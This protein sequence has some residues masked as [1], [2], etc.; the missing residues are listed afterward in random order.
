[1]FDLTEAVLGWRRR[2]GAQPDIQEGD[3][4][5]L[6]D[7]LRE[8]VAELR[9][10]GLSD[11][12]AFL[13]AARRLG[14]PETLAGEFATADPGLRRRLRLRWMVIG[15]LAVLVLRFASDIVA[16]SL[17]GASFWL[18]AGDSLHLMAGSQ[19]GWTAGLLRLTVFI[20]GA[21]L[22]WRLLTSDEAASRVKRSR[23]WSTGL[24]GAFLVALLIV[25]A[26]AT[27]RVGSAMLLSHGVPAQHI[28]N[29]SLTM[30]WLRWGLMLLLPML[31]LLMLWWLARPRRSAR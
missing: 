4:D 18:P 12:E 28:T 10:T 23:F 16:D 8:T 2:M 31:L 21:F 30:A 20:A 24:L 26:A 17:T 13:L 25:A 14:D 11:E 15:A 1:M 29:L 6:E 3:L 19:L 9:G 22:I 5:E 27:M 7:H